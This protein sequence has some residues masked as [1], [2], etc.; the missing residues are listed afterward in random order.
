[1]RRHQVNELRLIVIIVTTFLVQL[2]PDCVFP[3]QCNRSQYEAQHWRHRVEA[4][5]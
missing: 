3:C 4:L 5:A 1:M 2:F